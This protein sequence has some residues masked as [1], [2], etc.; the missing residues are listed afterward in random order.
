NMKEKIAGFIG[1]V[2]GIGAYLIVKIMYE[3]LGL[4]RLMA[5]IASIVT[6]FVLIVIIFT[7]YHYLSKLMMTP[8]EKAIE[9]QLVQEMEKEEL[10][11]QKDETSKNQ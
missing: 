5:I 1:T 9:K 8:E 4:S 2:L 3:N 11:K 7:G 6:V 10:E